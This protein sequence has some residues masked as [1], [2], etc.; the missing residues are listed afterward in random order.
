[1]TLTN[2][3]SLLQSPPFSTLLADPHLSCHLFLAPGTRLRGRALPRLL[4][5]LGSGGRFRGLLPTP[6]QEEHHPAHHPLP[7]PPALPHL[8]RETQPPVQPLHMIVRPHLPAGR[9]LH[10]GH[11]LGQLRLS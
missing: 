2:P 1:M 10:E 9:L 11:R 3:L 8:L 5:F 7:L 4:G 6:V